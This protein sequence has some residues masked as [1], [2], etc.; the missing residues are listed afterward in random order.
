M[1]DTIT[2]IP[3]GELYPHPDNPRH[4][5]GDVT[6]LAESIRA[7]GILQN[8]T[9]VRGRKGTDEEIDHIKKF[10][11]T[12][13]GDTKIEREAMQEIQEQIENR[14]VA[15]GYTVVIGHRRLAAAKLVGLTELPCAIVEMTHR[16]QIQTMMVE[17]MQRADLT[18]YE[19]ANGFQNNHGGRLDD[20]L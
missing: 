20:P 11:D 10:Y 16:E 7:K 19:Q 4:D 12:L 17:N 6:E 14:W 9:V 1:A 3:I 13:T 2:Q 15:T 8:L 18:V 5:V